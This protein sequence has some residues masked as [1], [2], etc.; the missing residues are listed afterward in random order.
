M[1]TLDPP[2]ST[3]EEFLDRVGRLNA[4]YRAGA[5]RVHVPEAFRESDRALD[6]LVHDLL[7]ASHAALEAA[8]SSLF[9]SLPVAFDPAESVGPYLAIVDRD[10]AGE[11]YRFLDMGALIATQAFGENDPAVV[12][13]VLDSLPYIT[14]RYAH[15][16]YQTVLSLR[17]KAALNQI[18]PA[19]TPRHFIVNTGA[20]AVENAIK[21]VLLNRVKTTED[22]EGGFIVSFEGAFH[23]RTLGSLAVTHRKKARL[24]FPTFDW[25][26]IPF[27]VEE[28]RAPKETL[29]RE[30]RS[31]KQLWDLLVS[32]RLPRAEKSRD[33]FRREID[34]IDEF[35]ARPEGDVDAFVQTQRALLTADVV[36]RSR[37]VAAV[38]VEPIQGE[39]GVRIASGRFM[40]QLRLLTRIYDVPLIFD[41]VQTG[42]GMTGRLWAHELFDLPCPPDLV[43]WA[44][45]AQNGVLFVSEALA[46]FFQEEKKFNT[47]WEGDSVGMVRLLAVLDKLD[48]DAVRRTGDRAR[49]GL[50]A[51][52]RDY[53]EI[54]KNVRGPGVMLGF[55]VQRAD[56][57]DALLDRAFRRG[58]L[59][60]KAGERSVRVYPRYDTEPQAIDEALAI[61]RLAIEDLVGGRAAGDVAPAVKVRVGTLAIPLDTVDVVDVT[62]ADFDA[63]KQQI[64]EVEQERYGPGAAYPP[65]VLRS[66]RRPL[67]QFQLETLEAT[68]A[69]P[70]AIGVVLRDRVSGRIVGYALGSALEN[71]DEEGVSSDPRFGEND[72]FYL[73]AMAILPTVQNAVELEH[74]LLDALRDRLVA[75]GYL[76]LS[77]LIEERMLETGPEWVRRGAVLQ[78]IENYLRSGMSFVYLQVPLRAVNP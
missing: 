72:A 62:R 77:T 5:M 3:V 13:A 33:T 54:L 29:R 70:G 11:P 8:S 10:A 63:L 31:L 32:G 76:Y 66:G 51:L 26:H 75:A 39:G 23:G 46:T 21:A 25:P 18:A 12:Q 48:L 14:S 16:E 27:P 20:E 44:K 78:Q 40:R 64:L 67:L 36:R 2:T 74:H 28:A 53:R 59:L 30:E 15:S 60:L 22:A 55:D 42:W 58:L 9:F 1:E 43:T 57:C 68:I 47:T 52:S 71:H 4:R 73:Q 37:R 17:L 24:G 61:L 56:L 19:G 7:P 65:D 45:K 69:N 6:D 38:L 50:E 49:L 41:E 35:L 34:A